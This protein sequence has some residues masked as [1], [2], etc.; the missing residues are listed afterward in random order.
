MVNERTY[1]LYG[2]HSIHTS[3]SFP[4]GNWF[5]RQ[6]LSEMISVL[7]NDV[8]IQCQR[9]MANIEVQMNSSKPPPLLNAK[10]PNGSATVTSHTNWPVIDSIARPTEYMFHENEST[11]DAFFLFLSLNV[12]HSYSTAFVCVFCSFFFFS[13][14]LI[15]YTFVVV[16]WQSV[17]E[18][19]M[20]CVLC[21]CFLLSLVHLRHFRSRELVEKRDS[22]KACVA[23]AS[24]LSRMTYVY[25]EF[26]ISSS[27]VDG[28]SEILNYRF[29]RRYSIDT[30]HMTLYFQWNW[31]IGFVNETS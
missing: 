3:H 12:T 26:F 10:T 16:F 2:M 8:S 7:W 9:I 31:S 15:P 23:W 1:V 22:G 14:K 20:L 27:R 21:V 5:P 25:D 17:G 29:G 18:L 13:G 6:F 28:Q 30:Q 4:F 24:S 11:C 19:S